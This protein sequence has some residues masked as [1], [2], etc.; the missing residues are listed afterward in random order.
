MATVNRPSRLREDNLADTTDAN[1]TIDPET[2]TT[3]DGAD[4]FEY[5][6]TT[7]DYD[8]GVLEEFP[9]L[10]ELRYGITLKARLE[11]QRNPSTNPVG[12]PDLIHWGRYTGTT[13]SQFNNDDFHSAAKF[14]RNEDGYIGFYHYVN[15]LNHSQISIEQYLF[16]VMGI[17]KKDDNYYW[18]VTNN[19]SFEEIGKKELIVTYCSYNLFNK[20]DLKLKYVITPIS[21]TKRTL[22]I[23]KSYQIIPNDL[24]SG[25]KVVTSLNV[26]K[27]S[28][29]YWNDLKV[30]LIIRLFVQLDDPSKQLPGLVSLP[31]LILDNDC[32]LILID[33]LISYLHKGYLS[34]SDP[35]YG[36]ITGC[37]VSSS[38][39]NVIKTNTYRNRLV[40]TLVRLCQ[41]D[42]T[43]GLISY[44]L[45]KIVQKEDWT[46]V[47]LLLLK[48]PNSERNSIDFVNTIHHYFSTH[49]MY[50]TQS[51]LILLE[52]VKFLIS[53][54]D[55]L[56]ALKI[57]E[58]TIKVLP[59]DFECWFLLGLCYTLV[60][61][62]ELALLAI[63]S[64]PIALN[65]Y[66]QMNLIS[67]I[68]DDF[69]TTFIDNF[70]NNQEPISEK[71]FL[72][73]FPTPKAYVNKAFER[74]TP[75]IPSE[76]LKQPSKKQPQKPPSG[77]VKQ[78]WDDIFIFNPF[79]RHPIT[80]NGFYKSPL[81]CKSAREM[82]LVDQNLI[83]LCGPDAFKLSLA[84]L[85]TSNA[86]CSILDFT[87][88]SPWGRC[89]D[90]L[91][92]I[93][94]RIGWNSLLEL[95]NKLFKSNSPDIRA[96]LS[97]YVVEN[98]GDNNGNS[99]RKLISCEPWL[100]QMFIIMV[101]D[102][103][104][105]AS[106]S[107]P[108]REQ[109]HSALEWEILGHLGW[110]TKYNLKSSIS[111]LITSVLGNID[112]NDFNYFGSVQ[113]LIIYDEFILSEVNNCK[114]DLFNDDYSNSLFSNKLILKQNHKLFASFTNALNNDSLPLDFI[115]LIVMK[116]TSWNLRWYQYLPD[117]LITKVLMKLCF[118][119]SPEF[120]LSK[121][122]IVFEQNKKTLASPSRFSL[123]SLKSK[124][125]TSGDTDHKHFD[126][127]DTIV[128]YF[129][130]LI[131]WFN[132]LKSE[133]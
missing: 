35:S 93:V 32:I 119:H 16:N 108:G 79:I 120:I 86:N 95:K 87:R 2:N 72:H 89:Y 33:L 88:K 78:L 53:K 66:N 130:S 81:I 110:S 133:T 74:S 75:T 44:T 11:F 47:T 71:S 118:L 61:D 96:K 1:I 30:S 15:G 55:Y 82:S 122:K 4:L 116:L 101:Q 63:N 23:D 92:S 37:A 51:C 6:L 31:E 52:Q 84:S 3:M 22:L 40:D 90:L 106:I 64:L 83:K 100:E 36:S 28:S 25:K 24:S 9:R 113:L 114:I 12:P 67:G 13:S 34:D 59:L 73:Y 99:L 49:E 68:E 125:S 129:E 65:E 38:N 132:N 127:N 14:S 121:I 39:S 43:G 76:T 111:S 60:N 8:Y 58:T 131:H 19:S 50:S 70:T 104:S 94:A 126:H 17:Y 98:N 107:S 80:G 7:H 91:S 117:Y 46:Y 26:G 45:D 105:L 115:L 128:A 124:S 29:S 109:N 97:Q 18:N 21:T 102:L 77:K 27:I 85:S 69:V 5:A 48:L 57:A 103:K 112:T 56:N 123:F 42:L 20:S 10:R 62:Y 54:N 41:L